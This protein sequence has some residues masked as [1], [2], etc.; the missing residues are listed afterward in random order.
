MVP[1]TVHSVLEGWVVVPLNET[2][3]ALTS[4]MR[5]VI[6]VKPVTT[7]AS[8]LTISP[9]LVM[10]CGFSCSSSAFIVP[11]HDSVR[12]AALANSKVQINAKATIRIRDIAML[13]PG[14]TPRHGGRLRQP[15]KLTDHCGRGWV[16]ISNGWSSVLWSAFR[17]KND[18][19]PH[20]FVRAYLPG[21]ADMRTTIRRDHAVDLVIRNRRPF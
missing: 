8:K 12:T 9:M 3:L 20:P 11:S 4:S 6:P 19:E 14:T 7:P 5:A 2:E 17:R 16:L 18:A 10:A 21:S 1:W 15:T 13:C